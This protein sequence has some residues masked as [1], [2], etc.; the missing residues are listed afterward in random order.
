MSV[1]ATIDTEYRAWGGYEDRREPSAMWVA[2][3]TVTGDAT[4][5]T[6]NAR[7]VFNQ[8]TAVR[9]SR[10]FSIEN[11]SVRDSNNVAK[12]CQLTVN[13]LDPLAGIAKLQ[14]YGLALIQTQIAA[15]LDPASALVMRGL[16]LGVQGVIGIETGI[17]IFVDNVNLAALSIAAEG[18][19]WG[20]R[21]ASAAGGGI[22]RPL[23]GLYRN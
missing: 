13:N 21:S 7:I 9:L 17:S 4:G 6:R 20:A 8:A 3:L 16:F 22:I 12:D 23:R 5:G 14:E 18:Y 10:Y 2:Q 1:V 15:E 19:V 11:L